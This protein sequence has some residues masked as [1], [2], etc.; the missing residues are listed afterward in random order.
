MT[1]ASTPVI[2]YDS[3]LDHYNHEDCLH[4]VVVCEAGKVVDDCFFTGNDHKDCPHIVTI[5][6]AGEITDECLQ[7]AYPEGSFAGGILDNCD[8][9]VLMWFID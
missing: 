9:C 1:L 2:A 4:V 7:A 8:I 5:C 6:E 3:S